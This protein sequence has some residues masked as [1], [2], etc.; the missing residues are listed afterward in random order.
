MKKCILLLSI[1]MIGIFGVLPVVQAQDFPTKP[2]T[3]IVPKNPGG[4]HDIVSRGMAS[5]AQ[6]YLGQ[7]MLVELK[8]GGGGAIGAS[9]VA[10]APADGYTIL[11]GDSGVNS[12][13]PAEQPKQKIGPDDMVPVCILNFSL[14]PIFVR[15]DAP[16]KT[17]KEFLDYAKKHPNEVRYA[18]AGAGGWNEMAWELLEKEAGIKTRVVPYEGGAAGML[19]VLGGHADIT[20]LGIISAAAHIKAGTL[21]PI[22]VLKDSRVKALP[23][24]P[25]GKELGINVSVPFWKGMVAP[26]GTPK[27]VIDKLAQAFKKMSEDP[28]VAQLVEKAG[29]EIEFLGP[30]EFGK[31]WRAEYE[32]QKKLYPTAK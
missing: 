17:F 22:L 10:K 25:T 15:S 8:P 12:G 6:K 1:V 2:V 21:R 9:F 19:A 26:K 30:E 11:F 5:V 24:V 13:K 28:A 20:S 18:S 14:S 4:A 32:G 16:Y 3:V 27:P 31:L 29:D 7:P 23:N